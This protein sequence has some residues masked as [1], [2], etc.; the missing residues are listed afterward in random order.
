M[1]I[2]KFLEDYRNLLS[3]L[4]QINP[5]DILF[6]RDN[7]YFHTD[8]GPILID[9]FDY[10]KPMNGAPHQRFSVRI[11]IPDGRTKNGL[12]E[13]VVSTFSLAEMPSCCAIL[14][15]CDVYVYPEYRK[16]GV[17]KVLNEFRIGIAK[18]LGYS[19]MMCTD[20]ETNIHQRKILSSNGWKDIHNIRNKRTNNN[21]FISVINLD[22][23]KNI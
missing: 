5:I 19:L 15:S 23:V 13:E 3:G 21:V 16:K 22:D 9:H 17:G 14:I 10:Y 11:N 1:E 4:L 20:I 12:R 18:E 2:K 6:Y 8:N 7:G